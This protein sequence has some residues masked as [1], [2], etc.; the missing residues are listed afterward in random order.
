MSFTVVEQARTRLNRSEL[1]VPGS[2]PEFFDKAAKSAADVVFIDLED[3]VAPDEKDQARKNA[4]AALNEIDWGGKT[5][6]V[7]VN[8]LDTPHMYRDV[9]D[10]VERGGRRLDLLMIPKV[11]VAADVYALDMLV[12]QIERAKGWTRRIGLELIIESALGMTNVE[13]IAAASLR[14]ET[15]HFGVADFAGSVRARTTGMGGANPDYAVLTHKNRDGGRETHWGDPWHYGL[16]RLVVA[17]RARGLRPLDGPFGD[18]QDADGYLAAAKRAAALGYDGKWA[19][20]PSQVE[21]ANAAFSP[22]AE[23]LDRARRI[24][25]AMLK[26]RKEGK[27][28]VALDGK[29]IDAASIRQAEAVVG[30]ERLIGA[31]AGKANAG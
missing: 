5:V 27:G 31:A 19:V 3:S 8:G 2:R 11:G 30:K 16:A 17:A 4:V 29:I 22:S 13:A 1:A 18:F 24:I 10:V 25:G 21:L 12:T 14:N 7:R 9:V 6:S 15:L 28:A 23:E 20:H 26:A